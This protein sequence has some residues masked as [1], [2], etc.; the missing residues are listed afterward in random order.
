MWRGSNYFTDPLYPLDTCG[1]L[2]TDTIL[3]NP[4]RFE[5]HGITHLPSHP[6]QVLVH[7]AI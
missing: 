4:Y 5:P 1:R 7:F 3:R 2:K 6:G